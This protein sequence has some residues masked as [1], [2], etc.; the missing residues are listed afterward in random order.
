VTSGAGGKAAD[1]DIAAQADIEQPAAVVMTPRGSI[2]Q[3]QKRHSS[4]G[5][6]KAATIAGSLTAMLGE[7][8][9]QHFACNKHSEQHL[10][11]HK[12]CLRWWWTYWYHMLQVC[13][14]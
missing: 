8:F 7:C 5:T 11:L 6:S 2:T 14:R 10:S 3:P 13:A 9:Q 4:G 1:R 12:Q